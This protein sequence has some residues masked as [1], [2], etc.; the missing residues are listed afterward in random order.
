ML[1]LITTPDTLAECQAFCE[2]LKAEVAGL[3][4]ALRMQR[5]GVCFCQPQ[6]VGSEWSRHSDGCDLACRL[7]GVERV[8]ESRIVNGPPAPPLAYFG[9]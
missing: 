6:P 3:R 4:M 1:D 9:K 8:Y 2:Q 5:R 7:L